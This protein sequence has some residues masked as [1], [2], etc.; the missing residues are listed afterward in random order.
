MTRTTRGSGLGLFIVKGLVEAMGG[1][2]EL[3]SDDEYGFIAIITLN[4]AKNN[5][6]NS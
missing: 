3:N 5:E 1:T 4:I 2:I 6:V